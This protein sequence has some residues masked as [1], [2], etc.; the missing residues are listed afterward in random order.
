[1]KE[2]ENDVPALLVSVGHPENRVIWDVD[3]NEP[4]H[5]HWS[6]EPKKNL[7]PFIVVFPPPAHDACMYTR[8]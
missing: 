5:S 7:V 6:D 4:L 8:R 3:N 2:E 1:M